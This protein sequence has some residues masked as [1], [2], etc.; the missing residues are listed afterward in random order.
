[1]NAELLK[2]GLAKPYDE[3]KRKIDFSKRRIRVKNMDIDLV[4]GNF[5]AEVCLY[6]NDCKQYL[7]AG[8]ADK[9]VDMMKCEFEPTDEEFLI[10]YGLKELKDLCMQVAGRRGLNWSHRN[11]KS[12][13]PIPRCFLTKAMRGDKIGLHQAENSDVTPVFSF[14]KQSYGRPERKIVPNEV[15]PIL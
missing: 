9:S 11:F 12:E 5:K 14:A 6:I 15:R 1:M 13:I 3:N 7:K 8:L 10:I 2:L 4:T